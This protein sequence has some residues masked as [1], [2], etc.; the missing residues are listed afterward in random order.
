MNILNYSPYKIPI[1]YRK[2]S[3]GAWEF[4]GYTSVV[5]VESQLARFLDKPKS[6][7]IIL[8]S[9]PYFD[10]FVKEQFQNYSD[11]VQYDEEIINLFCEENIGICENIS[12]L[13][14]RKMPFECVDYMLKNGIDFMGLIGEV[15]YV[16][17]EKSVYYRNE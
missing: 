9:M 16:I 14:Y 7:K 11:R 13:D 5:G 15:D 17:D 3:T 4:Y 12:D 8:K 2:F 6:F 10:N 1:A